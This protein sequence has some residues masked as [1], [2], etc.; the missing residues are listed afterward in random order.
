MQQR[1]LA[2]ANSTYHDEQLAFL[3][4]EIHLRENI[5]LGLCVLNIESNMLGSFLLR[6]HAETP[7]VACILDFD[8]ATLRIVI[9][10]IF[11]RSSCLS[12]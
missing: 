5:F 1:S 7:V 8:V 12:R 4:F 3:N 9:L 10:R 6:S 2:T 11:L